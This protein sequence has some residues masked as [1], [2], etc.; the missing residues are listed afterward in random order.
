MG[1]PTL[2]YPTLPGA[3]ITGPARRCE[4][5]AVTVSSALALPSL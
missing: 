5:A 2:P 3:A 4:T 1:S